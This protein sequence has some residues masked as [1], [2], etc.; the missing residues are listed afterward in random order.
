MERLVK[1]CWIGAPLLS[2]PEQF[3]WVFAQYF[4]LLDYCH[5]ISVLSDKQF[6]YFFYYA[7]GSPNSLLKSVV[8][9]CENLDKKLI[10]VHATEI[11][12]DKLPPKHI[13]AEYYALDDN[14]LSHWLSQIKLKYFFNH[15]LE[16]SKLLSNKSSSRNGKANFSEVVDYIANNIHR[17]LREEDA[18]ALCHY[19]TTYFSKVFRRKVGMCFRDY[20]TAKRISL[21]KKM[22]TEDNSTKIAYIAYKCGYHDV[23]YFSRIFKKKTGFSPAS[24]RQQ[25]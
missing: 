10:V 3:R 5:D 20:V 24:Y 7:S 23:S 6:D 12:D 9:L 22:L 21:A 18:A 25:F 14:Y 19:S 8:T 2:L 11:D 1:A 13:T 17:E 16:G 15:S 4:E